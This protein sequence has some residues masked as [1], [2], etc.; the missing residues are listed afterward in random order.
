MLNF[1]FQVCD[2]VDNTL[3][4]V[5]QKIKVTAQNI[6]EAF[7]EALKQVPKGHKICNWYFE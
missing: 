7:E 6:N 5:P 3:I 4:K 2:Y 1:V